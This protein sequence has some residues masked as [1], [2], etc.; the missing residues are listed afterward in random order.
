MTTVPLPFSLTVLP[1]GTQQCSW[2]R[3][4]ATSQ[5]VAGSIPNEVIGFFNSANPSSCTMD[6]GLTQPPTFMST[7]YLLGG[8]W[9]PVHKVDNLTAIC[10]PLD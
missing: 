3:H 6:L 8:K 7:R 1:W 9:W 4:Y 5:K 2:L 10:E